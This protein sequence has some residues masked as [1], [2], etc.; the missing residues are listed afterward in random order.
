VLAAAKSFL[1]YAALGFVIS[2]IACAYIGRWTVGE[3][4]RALGVP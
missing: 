3:V 2:M 1:Q 4:K